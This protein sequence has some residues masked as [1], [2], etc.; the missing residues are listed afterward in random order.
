MSA[1]SLIA[2]P[3]LS[4]VNTTCLAFKNEFLD[5]L[6][7]TSLSTA[8]TIK[9]GRHK[10]PQEYYHGLFKAYFSSRNEPGMEHDVNFKTSTPQLVY[11]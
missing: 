3:T 4:E 5:P 10:S 9:Q 1:G 8:L 2:N 11:S 7:L 6:A